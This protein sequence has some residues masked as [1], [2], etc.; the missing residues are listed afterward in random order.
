MIQGDKGTPEDKLRL[1]LIYYMAQKT[2]MDPSDL[3]ELKAALQA[4]GVDISAFQYLKKIRA[5]NESWAA[6]T[7]GATGSTGGKK[8]VRTF[9]L[10]VLDRP[11]IHESNPPPVKWWILVWRVGLPEVFPRAIPCKRQ[12]LGSGD[13]GLP[14]YACG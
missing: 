4:A 9:L 12:V 3:E 7:G 1:F 8:I 10:C 14:R 2:D 11:R 6:S 5:F 13:E